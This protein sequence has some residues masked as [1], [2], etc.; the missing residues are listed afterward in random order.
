[1]LGYKIAKSDHEKVIITLEIPE[2][3]LTNMNRKDVVDVAFAK[4]RTNKAK[5]ISI[6]DLDG[7]TFNKATSSHYKNKSLVYEVGK[8]VY[9]DDFDTNI[10]LICSSGIHYFL[11]KELAKMYDYK[12]FIAHTVLNG[13]HRIYY[14]NGRLYVNAEYKD[15]ILHGKKIMYNIN[16]GIMSDYNYVDGKKEGL[17]I[18][19]DYFG[20]VK[21]ETIYKNDLRNGTYKYYYN[22]PSIG[23]VYIEYMFKDDKKYGYD[24]LYDMNGKFIKRF[25]YNMDSKGNIS[26]DI[27][28]DLKQLDN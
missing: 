14:D 1:M 10:D 24:N 22:Y 3:A 11:D 15:G 18:D 17:C 9:V 27:Q 12:W 5:V 4:H 26:V 21:E 2:D 19:Y 6:E 13:P 28:Y 20:M 25:I 16:G 23:R 7:N 8:T